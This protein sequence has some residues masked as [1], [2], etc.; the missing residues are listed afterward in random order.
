MFAVD[1]SDPQTLWLNLT[2]AALGVVTLLAVLVVAGS[3]G[4]EL[5][6]RRRKTRE[7][8]NLDAELATLVNGGGSAHILPVPELGLTMADGGEPVEPPAIERRSKKRPVK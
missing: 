6:V 1:W 2:N 4:R 7:L 3:V 5:M 8:N